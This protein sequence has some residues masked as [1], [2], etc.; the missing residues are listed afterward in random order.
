M[1]KHSSICLCNRSSGPGL[2]ANKIHEVL[3]LLEREQFPIPSHPRSGEISSALTGLRSLA[4]AYA[5][6]PP[7]ER[8]RQEQSQPPQ[9]LD[10]QQQPHTIQVG[11]EAAQDRQEQTQAV[12]AAA[13]APPLG[14]YELINYLMHH[15][16]RAIQ[17]APSGSGGKKGG[18]RDGMAGSLGQQ[19]SLLSS[20]VCL[21]LCPCSFLLFFFISVRQRLHLYYKTPQKMSARSN[22][23]CRNS[24]TNSGSDATWSPTAAPMLMS[25]MNISIPVFM[26]C[27]LFNT[28][29][30]VRH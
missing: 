7:R 2:L 26:L 30:S 16:M 8:H 3:A 1:S 28:I 5:A 15:N 23:D 4:L 14:H 24:P 27:K 6:P 17:L 22:G 9:P 19:R 11:E 12:A 29:F 21:C 20:P 13:A 25:P 10:L 18:K